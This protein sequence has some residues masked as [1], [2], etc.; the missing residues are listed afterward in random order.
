MFS[1]SG[2]TEGGWGSNVE[3]LLWRHEI[4]KIN[5]NDMDVLRVIG[6]KIYFS[7]RFNFKKVKEIFESQIVE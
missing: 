4:K 5:G 6:L 3:M 2:S 1:Y 7:T